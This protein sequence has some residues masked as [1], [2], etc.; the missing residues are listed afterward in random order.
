MQLDDE[1]ILLLGEIAA[2][3]IGP[4]V[5]DPPEAAALATSE[6]PGGFRQGPPAPLAV[7]PDVRD[8]P[9]VLLLRPRAFVRVRLLAARRSPH[10]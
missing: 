2:L 8:Q 5:V 10:A 4:E 7:R 1:L 6:Q 3:E 9:I